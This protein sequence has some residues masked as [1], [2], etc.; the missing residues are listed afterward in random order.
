MD[1][2]TI[3]ALLSMFFIGMVLTDTV[4]ADGSEDAAVTVFEEGVDGY[5]RIRIPSILSLADGTL[6]AFAEGRLAGDHSENDLILKRS[7]DGGRTWGESRTIATRG[8][9]SLNDPLPVEVREGPRK[10]RVYLH[11]MSFPSGCHTPC[12]ESGY[13]P[14]SSQNWIVFSDDLGCTWSSPENVTHLFRRPGS[15]YG[16]SP[17]VGIQLRRGAHRGRIVL[18]LREGPIGAMRAYTVYSD[19][20]GDRWSRGDI[21]SNEASSGTADE[22]CLVECSDGSLLLN[23]RLHN[24]GPTRRKSARST[25]GGVTFTAFEVDESLITPHCMGSIIA[26]GKGA[27]VYYAGPWSE[28]KRIDGAIV[29]S[30]D[31]GRTWSEPKILV[32]GSFAYSQL[33]DLENGGEIGLLYET[34]GYQRIAFRRVPASQL[35]KIV[36]SSR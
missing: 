28:S 1:P 13:G 32:P 4:R 11:F 20:G 21:V 30:G 12:V 19:D 23:T 5:P 10:G 8:S 33:V 9:D 24:G 6:L 22:V 29:G 17:G 27:I 35:P 34:D 26:P 14:R 3:T 31:G 15:N 18:P 36:G 16:G 7:F 25:D 2:L